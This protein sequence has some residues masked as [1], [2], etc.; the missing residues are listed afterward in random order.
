MDNRLTHRVNVEELLARTEND[1]EL[2]RELLSIF[3]DEFPLKLKVLRDAALRG[4]LSQ[5]AVASHA[6]KGMLSNLSIAK[7]ASSAATLERTARSGQLAAVQRLL[8]EFEQETQGLVPEV[9]AQI[10][11]A[12]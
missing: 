6:L 12:P 10:E 4:D 9:Q 8:A 11:E 2:L 3:V 1:R 7:A 5:V